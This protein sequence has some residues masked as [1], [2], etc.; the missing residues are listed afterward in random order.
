MRASPIIPSPLPDE[1]LGGYFDRCRSINRL[2][3]TRIL[4]EDVLGAPWRHMDMS[5]PTHLGHFSQFFSRFLPSYSLDDWV[6]GHTFYPYYA[7]VLAPIRRTE[8]KERMTTPSFGPIR[9]TRPLSG[10]DQ[11]K[12]ARRYCKE[13]EEEDRSLFGTAY[14]HRTANL[15]LVTRCN[16]HGLLLHEQEHTPSSL[17]TNSV[18]ARRNSELYTAISEEIL[19][20]WPP[21]PYQNARTNFET[22]LKD[23]NWLSPN[24]KIALASL[25]SHIQNVFSAGFE[26][27][28][29]SRQVENE[30]SIRVWLQRAMNTRSTIH[31]AHLVLLTIC[32]KISPPSNPQVKKKATSNS[33]YR[34]LRQE[35]NSAAIQALRSTSTLRAAA[36]QCGLTVTTLA[37]IARQEGFSFSERPKSL[38]PDVRSDI[39]EAL[40]E[41]ADVPRIC[42]Q[43]GI[44]SCA[45]YRIINGSTSVRSRRKK[46]LFQSKRA[47]L[48]GDWN[49]NIR[50]NPSETTNILRQREPATY[51]WLYRNDR[52]WLNAITP[53]APKPL[54]VKRA[55]LPTLEEAEIGARRIR[56]VSAAEKMKKA[57]PRRLTEKAL[58]TSAGVTESL[59]DRLKHNSVYRNAVKS[60]IDDDTSYV[61]RRLAWAATK[62]RRDF[63][64][65]KD[66]AVH[67]AS[68]LRKSTIAKA[69]RK[70]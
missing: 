11:F 30:R 48:R 21:R 38:T 37:T 40:A 65:T 7:S 5:L 49:A 10:I 69:Q 2:S 42:E 23:A 32:L 6:S 66:W 22:E 63:G 14:L 36:A 47:K 19:H 25:I 4:Q 12:L 15:P 59:H 33:S 54:T 62:L 43:Y 18:A 26:S 27:F 56:E 28:D 61:E 31:P 41:G 24:G 17:I 44:S 55:R 35:Q 51:M 52:D 58:S 39:A 29:L 45:A 13:C 1:V 3:T 53:K 8:L 68:G 60:S 34:N 67:R 50:K 57:R 20:S 70:H 16:R 9:A 64:T 46:A